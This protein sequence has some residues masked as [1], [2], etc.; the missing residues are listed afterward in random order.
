MRWLTLVGRAE[1]VGQPGPLEFTEAEEVW[2]ACMRR[3]PEGRVAVVYSPRQEWLVSGWL[4]HVEGPAA[5]NYVR[6][7]AV[8]GD[9]PGALAWLGVDAP[10]VSGDLHLQI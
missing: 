8:R 6:V 9:L 1:I 2:A 4:T 10:V 5:L 7:T 3:V